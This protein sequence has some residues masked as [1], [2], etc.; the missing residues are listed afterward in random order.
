LDPLKKKDASV[1]IDAKIKS[2]VQ[3]IIFSRMASVA[4]FSLLSCFFLSFSCLLRDSRGTS[5]T[6]VGSYKRVT[7]NDSLPVSQYRYDSHSSCSH[8]SSS[9]HGEN[10]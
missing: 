1:F 10:P 5:L 8:V 3:E 6:D 4:A 9:N 2:S 7:G